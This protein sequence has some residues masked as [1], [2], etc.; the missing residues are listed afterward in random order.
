MKVLRLAVYPLKGGRGVELTEMSFDDMGP[1]HDR[2][3]MLLDANGHPVTQREV[4]ELAGV[5]P[6]VD[7]DRISFFADDAPG[8]LVLRRSSSFEDA[9]AL[10]APIWSSRA[11]VLPVR[12]G[13]P[14]L[15]RPP[16]AAAKTARAAMGP[17]NSESASIHDSSEA[18]AWF[19]KLLGI[20]C[21]LVQMDM[22]TPRPVDSAY[23]EGH[24]VALADGY[25]LLLISDASVRDLS[26]RTKRPIPWNRFRPNIVI[27]APAPH[28]EDLLRRF[29]VGGSEFRGVKLC[30]RCQVPTFDQVSGRRD[31]DGEP[32]RTLARYRKIENAVYFGINA[33][34]LGRTPIT[35]GDEVEALERAPVPGPR[36]PGP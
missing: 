32:L 18:D 15:S 31:P 26:R 30:A 25:P 7:A 24:Y 22:K 8:P 9:R 19:S 3:W 11:R 13:I 5:R 36:S 34:H 29:S 21:R 10:W 27:S 4:P 28:E 14:A 12:K 2:R 17:G 35:V 6:E 20:R 23:A 1:I 16:S 33:V